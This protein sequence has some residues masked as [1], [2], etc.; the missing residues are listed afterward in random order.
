MAGGCKL[1][2]GTAGPI[3]LGEISLTELTVSFHAVVELLGS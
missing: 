3:Q 2:N 1:C